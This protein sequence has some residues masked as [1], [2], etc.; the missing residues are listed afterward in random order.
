[1]IGNCCPGFIFPMVADVYH[2]IVEQGAYGNV[3]KAWILDRT[4]SCNFE[5]ASAATK[6]E[7]KANLAVT[8]SL[9]LS[10]RVTSD[11]RFTSEDG[12]KALTNIIIT[13]IKDSNDNDIYIETSGPRAGMPTLFEIATYEPVIGPFGKADYYKVVLRRSDNQEEDV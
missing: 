11:I 5:P 4:V 10:G 3:S 2:P 12:M 8:T 7:I 6:E 13:N 9:I 1:M